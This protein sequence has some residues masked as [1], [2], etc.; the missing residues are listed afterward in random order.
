MRVQ[1]AT[2]SQNEIRLDCLL[3]DC[4]DTPHPLPQIGQLYFS[5]IS[6]P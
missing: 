3:R 1:Y 2:V 6:V 5:M 4:L